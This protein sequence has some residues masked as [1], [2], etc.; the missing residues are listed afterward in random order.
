MNDI[1][2]GEVSTSEVIQTANL[3]LTSD[4]PDTIKRVVEAA[5]QEISVRQSKASTR[6]WK[7]RMEIQYAENEV[8]ETNSLPMVEVHGVSGYLDESRGL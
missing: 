2:L 3:A 4:T 5:K 1:N 7:A 8:R 6:L